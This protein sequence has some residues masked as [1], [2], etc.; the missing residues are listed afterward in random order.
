M[1]GAALT[2]GIA[3]FA[4]AAGC[5]GLKE[6]PPSVVPQAGPVMVEPAPVEPTPVEA[7]EPPPPEAPPAIEIEPVAAVPVPAPP[8]PPP[9]SQSAVKAVLPPAKP[10]VKVSAAAVPIEE[11]QKNEEPPAPPAALKKVDPPLD[12]AA[13]KA[14]LR[15][16]KAIGVFTKLAL[17]NQMDDLLKQFRAHHDSGQKTSVA[18]LRQP[19]DMLVFKVVAVVQDGDPSLARTISE[20]R[21]AIWD[22]LADP[23]KFNSVTLTHGEA[24]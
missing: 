1:R 9:K 14:R 12:V 23:E 13:L 3:F 11:P 2:I 5:A 4:L 19:Y 16:T 7:N 17:Q 8:A 18:S 15:S 6:A 21:E 20:S 10:A 22:I 24:S